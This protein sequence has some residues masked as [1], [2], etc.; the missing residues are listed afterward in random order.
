MIQGGFA[1]IIAVVAMSL[2]LLALHLGNKYFE[3]ATQPASVAINEN[4]E[5]YLK[6]FEKEKSEKIYIMWETDAGSIEPVKE[7]DLFKEQ[8]ESSNNKKYF[9]NTNYDESIRWSS[10]DADGYE[11]ETATVRAI[12]YSYD[13]S[14]NK[15]V[16]YMGTYVNE[17]TITVTKSGDTI[18]KADTRFFGNPVRENSSYDW[19]QIYIVAEDEEKISYRYRTGNKI[20]EE[21]VILCFEANE[22]VLSETDYEKGMYYCKIK[23]DNADRNILTAVA[24]VTIKKTDIEGIKSLSVEAYLVNEDIYNKAVKGEK[25][26]E[27]SKYN[28]AGIEIIID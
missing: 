8:Q 17:Y 15:D 26:E 12:V 28:K 7:N 4:G 19:N 2:Y 11:Y 1:V 6:G 18:K 22:E 25:V 10:K 9:V 27:S 5:I 13:E 23:D 24:N 14:V 16:Y 3:K 21:N 20:D